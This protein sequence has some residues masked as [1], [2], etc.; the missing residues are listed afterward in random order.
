MVPVIFIAKNPTLQ[1]IAATAPAAWKRVPW[2]TPLKDNQPVIALCEERGFELLPRKKTVCIFMD[3]VRQLP[4]KLQTLGNPVI[5]IDAPQ[6]GCHFLWTPVDGSLFNPLPWENRRDVICP[7]RLKGYTDRQAALVQL[8]EIGVKIIERDDSARSYQQYIDELCK[9]K[10]VVNFCVDRKTGFPQLKGR[11]FET[12]AAGALLLEQSNG[13]TGHWLEDGEYFKW[14]DFNE[15]AALV[16]NIKFAPTV[17]KNVAANGHESF[18]K[19][20]NAEKFWQEILLA[21]LD[22]AFL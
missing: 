11:V 3:S 14:K 15:L 5:T 8:R 16:H 6:P 9:A 1:Q 19:F 2:S 7:V 22:K 13:I 18:A 12:L 10:A 17:E 4:G 20:L 21:I